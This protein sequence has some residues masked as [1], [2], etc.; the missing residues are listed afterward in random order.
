MDC[1]DKT[2]WELDTQIYFPTVVP[3]HL[4]GVSS[5][6]LASLL[7]G[8]GSQRAKRVYTEYE[9]FIQITRGPAVPQSTHFRKS[10]SLTHWN[11]CFYL[12]C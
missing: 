8:T 11:W 4:L 5:V 1:V 12:R 10:E 7:S 6:H 3:V 2:H 9:Q